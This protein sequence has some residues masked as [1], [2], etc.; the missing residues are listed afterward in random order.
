MGVIGRM[1]SSVAV[2]ASK[3]SGSSAFSM[4]ASSCWAVRALGLGTSESGERTALAPN[5]PDIKTSKS[6]AMAMASAR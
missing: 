5:R 4:M 2:A 3:G 6:M 1:A